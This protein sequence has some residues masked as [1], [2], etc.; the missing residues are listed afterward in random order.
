VSWSS[1]A[2]SRYAG[3]GTSRP[4]LVRA[5]GRV[6]GTRRPPNTTEPRPRP[7]R[8]AARSGSCLPFGPHAAAISASNIVCITAIP[9]ATLIASSPSLATD[10]MSAR[11]S[12]NSAGRSVT[13]NSAS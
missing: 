3:S 6:T 5:R 13:P 2:N 4:S 8:V 10:A 12:W 7:W 1:A 9:A 11:A